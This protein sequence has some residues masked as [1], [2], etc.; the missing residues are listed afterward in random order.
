M[1]FQQT[2]SWNLKVIHIENFVFHEQCRI[3]FDCVARSN[4]P[5][6]IEFAFAFRILPTD[7]ERERNQRS[8]P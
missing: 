6:A 2:S 3:E 8:V 7:L 5:T 4:F 1:D